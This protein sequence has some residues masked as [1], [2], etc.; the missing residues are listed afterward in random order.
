MTRSFFQFEQS[1]WWVLVILLVSAASSYF[2]YSKKNVPWNSTQN[3][4]LFGLRSLAIFLILLLLLEPSIKKVVNTLEKPIIAL[5]IDN[6]QSIIARDGDS[7][8]IK[9]KISQLEEILI[10]QDIDIKTLTLSGSDS[11][12]FDQRTSRLSGL[13]SEVDELPNDQN[14]VATILLTDGIFNRGSSPLYRNYLQPVFT[15]GMGDTISPKDISISRTLYNKVTFK[16]NETPIRLEISQTGY[17]MINS[18]IRLSEGGKTLQE[19]RLTLNADVQEVEFLVASEEEGLKHLVASIPAEKDEST[20]ENNRVD[21][22]LEVID[23]RQKILI[24]ANSPHPDIKAIRR[25]L[26]QTDSYVTELYIPT[27]HEEKPREFYDVVIYHGAFNSGINFNPKEQPGLWYILNSES[28][29][30]SANK[31]LNYLNIE[32]R[33]GQADKVSGSFN[34]SF[35]KFKID[36]TEIFEEYPPIEVPFG[37]YSVS[38]ASEILM[39]QKLGSVVTKKPLMVVNDDGT[40]KSAVLMGQNIWRWKLQEAA[41]NDN[42]QQFDN[43]ITKTIQF[44]SVK[45]DKKQFRFDSRSSSFSNTQPILFDTEVYNEIYERIYGNL[46]EITITDENNNAN[47]YEFVDSELNSTFRA[48]S[49]APGIYQFS[50]SVKIGD[51]TFT[52]KGEFLIENVN[53]EY[54]NL[55]ANHRL[56]RNLASKTGGQFVHY[57]D[58]ESLPEIIESRDFKPIMR[59]EEDDQDLIKSWWYFL[60]IF[61][62]FSV[63]WILRRYWGGY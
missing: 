18:S 50:A 29:I 32:R 4:I 45:N 30:N 54:L 46:I 3:W 60:I 43:F 57:N 15:V 55:T 59:S 33:S 61:M 5:A 11:M 42:S 22:F 20:T 62:L 10:D 23:G 13:L 34:Q 52:E 14:L 41:I 19:K 38:G 27:I 49:L 24:V 8:E 63:E 28:A 48:P 17:D 6:S 36:N 44:L 7:I 58:M 21:I 47:E 25:S 1:A 26:E 9:N 12:L 40:Q 51:D 39:Y 35:S 53:P 31:T 16:G 2:L 56:L 37:D